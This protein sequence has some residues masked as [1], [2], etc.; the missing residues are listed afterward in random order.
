MESNN[1]HVV[2]S[3]G[4]SLIVPDKIDVSF[5][6][7]FVALI[8]N[9]VSQGHKFGIICGGGH[10]AREYRDALIALGISDMNIL[11]LMLFLQIS[12]LSL[13]TLWEHSAQL[14]PALLFQIISLL[15]QI[16]LE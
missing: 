10:V 7:D 6:K 16:D 4:G 8:K 5:V 15:W 12:R 3:L 14:L 11:D 9:K 1:T 2:I 13:L